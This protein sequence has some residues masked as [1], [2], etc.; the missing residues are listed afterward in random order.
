MK[1]LILITFAYSLAFNLCLGNGKD[2]ETRT[3]TVRM[4]V[5]PNDLINI[6]AKN[7][8]LVVE[9]WD[10]SEVE[11]IATLRFD[12]KMTDKMVAF[13]DNFQEHVE[14]SIRRS[15]SELS[16]DTNLDEPNK[17]QIGSKHVGIV[18]GFSEDELR[19]D[20]RI[21]APKTNELEIDNSYKDVTLMGDFNE[22]TLTQY[23]G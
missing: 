14:Q 23:S 15:G 5:S 7:T 16:I 9:S 19:L 10:K 18:I 13:L 8:D 3:A 1:R 17:I 4:E 6:R 20:Y 12:G 2:F 11:V 22:V 21:K